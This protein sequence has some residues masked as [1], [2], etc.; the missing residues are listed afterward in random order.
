MRAA[1][2]PITAMS[3]EAGVV[4]G[5][6][7]LFVN[8]VLLVILAGAMCVPALLDLAT[9]NADWRVF[10]G[11][12][13]ATAYP[14]GMLALANRGYGGRIDRRTAY[15]LT[16]SAWCT[17]GAFGSLPFL[18][19][20]LKMSVTD[21]VFET[22]SGLTTTGSTVIVGLDHLPIG[23][24]MWR[25]LLQWFGGVG[26]IVMAILLLARAGCRRHATVPHGII[27]Y[28]GELRPAAISDGAA[29]RGDVR[30]PDCNLRALIWRGRH[31]RL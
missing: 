28:F 5:R 29:H 6:F 4:S 14:G 10:A 11:S 27:R 17:I 16:V 21:A 18:F 22:M 15:A 24:L 20:S 31:E 1:G 12:A 13:L 30:R 8:G 7:V 26:I 19:S 9:A 3:A 2:R 25:S 23:L